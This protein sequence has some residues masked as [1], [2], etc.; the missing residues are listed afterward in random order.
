MLG[1]TILGTVFLWNFNILYV[2]RDW[3]HY[4]AGLQAF[5][6]VVVILLS[7]ASLIF[8][9]QLKPVGLADSLFRRGESLSE[10]QD[11][12]LGRSISRMPLVISLV[13]VVGFFLGPIMRIV[14][15]AIATGEPVLPITLF[16]SILFSVS[17]G[18]YVAFLEIRLIEGFFHPLQLKRGRVS[19]EQTSR[20]KWSQRQLILGMTLLMLTFGL[21]FSAGMGYLK[22]E[23]TAPALVDG[24]SSASES[25]DFRTDLWRRALE[26]ETLS[27]DERNP[28]I[29]LRMRE[30]LLKMGL[31][32]LI[33]LVLS[34][35]AIKVEVGPTQKRMEEMNLRLKDLSMGRVRHADKLV[36]VRGD[37]LGETV[38]WINIVLEQQQQIIKAMG[39]SVN[40]LGDFSKEL[41][42][43]HEI[44]RNLGIGIE[45]GIGNVR[46][47]L[48]L[49]Q[50]AT[51]GVERDA[52]GLQTS[53]EKTHQNL[54]NQKNAL[55]NN[56]ASMEEMAANIASV[57]KNARGAYNR[58][59]EMMEKAEASSRELAELLK[60]IQD[61]T[62]AATE[63]NQR[64]GQIAKLAS[65]TNLLAMNAAIE[66]AHAGNVGAGFAVV[67]AEVRTLAED[68]SKTAKDM[69]EMIKRMNE[70]SISGLSQ[71]GHAR[72]SFEEIR[73]SVKVNLSVI[74]EIS[75]A[76]EEQETGSNEMQK[77]LDEM[78]RIATEVEEISA[79]Q[80][81]QGRHVSS[82]TVELNQAGGEIQHQMEENA[83]LIKEF[84]QCIES[85]GDI[86]KGN[87]V[88]V[89]EL[90]TASQLEA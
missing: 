66:A 39:N 51:K 78:D 61:T 24:V 12:A 15:G 8:W 79:S 57:S 33:T 32:G 4:T 71:A 54:R 1:V 22:E 10:D 17:I 29:G 34:I 87:A 31:L 48:D 56:S 63:V 44:A 85:L 16:T 52:A 43:I 50:R 83:R 37:E 20:H 46:N 58:T 41:E 45:E 74:S 27:L 89:D 55:D 84:E 77:A 82:S 76:M 25:V 64:V 30:F 2:L 73:E 5:I 59:Q 38:H 62:D 70:L 81:E 68:S 21:F 26:G 49:Q 11:K 65:Q 19:I 14:G 75:R 28:A 80:E 86:I 47:N 69:T 88:V 36:I 35:I 7:A 60:G 42:R 53:I 9:I 6:T 67:A 23:L 40:S 72:D 90:K 13:S 18:A 3:S